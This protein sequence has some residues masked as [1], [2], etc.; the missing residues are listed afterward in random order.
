M[1]IGFL[2]RSFGI[3]TLLSTLLVYGSIALA[4]WGAWQWRYHSGVV[5]GRAEI[6]AEWEAARQAEADRVAKAVA[7]AQAEAQKTIDALEKREEDLNAELEKA[8]AEADNDPAAN[9]C[10]LGADSVQRL[11]RL[12]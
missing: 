6:R 7:E 3:S 2:A 1:I 4:A 11:Q 8:R 12:R 10:G 5:Q 9:E